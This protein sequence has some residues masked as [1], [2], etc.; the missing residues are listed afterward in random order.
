[1]LFH[2]AVPRS[3]ADPPGRA[4][5]IGSGVGQ[6]ETAIGQRQPGAGALVPEPGHRGR[7]AGGRRPGQLD[8][9]ARLDRD[10][11][12][13]RDLPDHGRDGLDAFPGNRVGDVVEVDQ[14]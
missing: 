2:G 14:M 9:T 1:V 8:L 7:D 4:G 12:A 13:R 3:R 5:R 10:R 11:G 6:P